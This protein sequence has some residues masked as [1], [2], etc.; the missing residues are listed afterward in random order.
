MAIKRTRILV[1]PSYSVWVVSTSANPSKV[2]D[3]WVIDNCVGDFARYLYY[4]DRLLG[5]MYD[6]ANAADAAMFRLWWG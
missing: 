4:K 5:N 6:F 2:I 1:V 3:R